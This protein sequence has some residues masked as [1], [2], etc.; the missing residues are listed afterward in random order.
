V[1]QNHGVST[2]GDLYGDDNNPV[3]ETIPDSGS[4][5]V[6]DYRAMGAANVN[7]PEEFGLALSALT[8]DTSN[9]HIKVRYYALL[10]EQAGRSDVQTCDHVVYLTGQVNTGLVRDSAEIALRM[11]QASAGS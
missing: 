11:W 5:F 2:I 1:S 9:R 8:P 10:R 4:L 6:I 3:L 7:T